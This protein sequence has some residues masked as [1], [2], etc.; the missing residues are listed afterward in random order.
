MAG[1][2]LDSGSRPELAVAVG[3]T[4]AAAEG[5]PSNHG[6]ASL[7]QL[8]EL[9]L[10]LGPARE[11]VGASSSGNAATQTNRDLDD[12]SGSDDADVVQAPCSDSVISEGACVQVLPLE[13]VSAPVAAAGLKLNPARKKRCG[14]RGTVV[15][16]EDAGAKVRVKFEDHVADR[17]DTAILGVL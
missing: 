5:I 3:K 7:D 16:V 14:Q 17:C 11:D 10:G 6:R 2:G 13:Q 8:E 12:Q 1:S 9:D 15:S 4:E